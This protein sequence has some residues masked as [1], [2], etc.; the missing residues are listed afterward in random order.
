MQTDSL[1]VAQ[2]LKEEQK[3]ASLIR[4]P[5]CVVVAGSKSP[6]SLSK[7]RLGGEYNK[8]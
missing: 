8:E 1:A 3:S 7:M 4:C 5:L 2:L 6:A